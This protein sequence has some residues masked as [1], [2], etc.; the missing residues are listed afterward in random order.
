MRVSTP[1][2]AWRRSS[3]PLTPM[4]TGAPLQRNGEHLRVVG[5]SPVARTCSGR[6]DVGFPA[7]DPRCGV[8]VLGESAAAWRSRPTA[9]RRAYDW[10]ARTAGPAAELS[11]ERQSRP[12]VARSN[13]ATTQ[14]PV[15]ARLFLPE[16]W[17]A[18]AARRERAHVPQDVAHH[19][20]PA[21][22]LALVDRARAWGVP[23]AFVAADAGYGQ[24]PAFL[25]GLE[26]RGVPYACG[27]KR[28][29][30]AAPA[31]RG[32][33]RP[34]RRPRRPYQGR[35]RPR[36]APARRPCGTRR[37]CWP[38]CPTTPWEAV[39]WRAGTK[40]ALDQGVRRRAGAPRHR[41]PGRGDE[42]AQRGPRAGHHRPRRA[43]CWA[44]APCPAT[45]GEPKQYFLWLPGWP[46]ETP[47]ARLVTLA[48]ARWAVEQ[49]YEDAKGEC[50]LADYQGRRWD[51]LHR[52]L[53]LTWL[54]YTFLVLQRLA[55]A[56]PP[57]PPEAPTAPGSPPRSA[58]DGPAAC[59]ATGRPPQSPATRKKSGRAA[60]DRRPSSASVAAGCPASQRT[61]AHKFAR[62][63]SS[64]VI[65]WRRRGPSRSG[66]ACSA[67]AR[68]S[69][70]C[71]RHVASSSPC[72]LRHSRAYSRIVSSSRNREL[73]GGHAHSCY[74][75]VRHQ[76]LQ[77]VLYLH[78]R[79]VG[80]AGRGRLR[81]EPVL[82]HAYPPEERSLVLGEEVVAPGDRGAERPLAL[83]EVPSAAGQQLQPVLEEFEHLPGGL[84]PDAAPAASS[85]ASGSPSSAV[86]ISA[87]GP[88][89]SPQSSSNSRCTSRARLAKRTTAG[90]AATTPGGGGCPAVGE[91][92][93]RER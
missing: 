10:G 9:G 16:P 81:R 80:R 74:Q 3:H 30:R 32:R 4:L 55:A 14:P 21:L 72:I 51:G 90:T 24:A 93:Q 58:P 36:A 83:R 82:E 65:H 34:R 78:R 62:S 40:G 12:P 31:R 29:L 39:T 11:V 23:F 89:R 68:K 48:H 2:L 5:P 6:L 73:A 67:R 26:A 60:T 53:A 52:H 56:A 35:G 64:R 42:R 22:G 27:V 91:V 88:S 7:A 43:G 76:R 84:G 59:A 69:A 20:K 50:G 66:S 25:A 37:P 77:S 86:Q 92:R 46:L 85:M 8:P 13:P 1:P 71:R 54:A 15:S 79:A 87:Y 19:T 38:A 28:D 33:R 63:A 41:Q 70:A 61:A 17:A 45:T 47:L 57:D 75:A 18:V 44:S 49:A